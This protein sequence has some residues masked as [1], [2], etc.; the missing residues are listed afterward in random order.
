MDRTS[1][2]VKRLLDLSLL[3]N[4]SSR[5]NTTCKNDFGAFPKEKTTFHMVKSFYLRNRYRIPVFVVEMTN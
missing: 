1:L 5:K 4:I 2:D 3:F